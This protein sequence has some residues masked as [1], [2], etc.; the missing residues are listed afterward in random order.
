MEEKQEHVT[1]PMLVA[2]HEKFEKH[3][4]VP[5]EE[6]LCSDEWVWNFCKM[7]VL[8][9]LCNMSANDFS[10]YNIREIIR[11]GEA[12]SVDLEA[13]EKEQ[14]RVV[15]I[16]RQYKPEDNL[17]FDKSGLFGLYDNGFSAKILF[18]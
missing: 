1:G 10:R 7:W 17:N 13:V 9:L 15:G 3:L 4:N 5:E 2:K 6:R 18:C 8:Y 12:G 11:H 14:H 16:Y